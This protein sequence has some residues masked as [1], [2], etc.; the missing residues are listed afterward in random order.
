MLP[1]LASS[2][3]S[4]PGRYPVA[5]EDEYSSTLIGTTESRPGYL[6]P[7]LYRVKSPAMLSERVLRYLHM[8]TEISVPGASVVRIA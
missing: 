3:R 2:S 1:A 6:S 5:D 7:G 8:L 4:R